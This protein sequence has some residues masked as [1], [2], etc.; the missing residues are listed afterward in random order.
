MAVTRTLP[1]IKTMKIMPDK[2]LL[3]IDKLLEEIDFNDEDVPE[4]ELISPPRETLEE[5][6]HRKEQIVIHIEKNGR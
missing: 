2:R 4:D 5:Y 3:D 6:L 1:K